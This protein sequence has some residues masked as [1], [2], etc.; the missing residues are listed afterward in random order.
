MWKK[1]IITLVIILIFLATYGLYIFLEKNNTTKSI[2]IDTK[3]A[4]DIS[5]EEEKSN[6][7]NEKQ[8]EDFPETRAFHISNDD[9]KNEC[10]NFEH[11]LKRLNYCQNFCGLLPIKN[12]DKK[13]DCEEKEGLPRDY[14][15]RDKA[16]STKDMKKCSFIRDRGIKDYCKNR[17]TEDI[18]DESF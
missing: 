17:I 13:E 6:K 8:H 14:C 12:G 15:F 11:D 18:I 7:E 3:S 1:I 16:I 2:K 9:C 10:A 4:K 5:E